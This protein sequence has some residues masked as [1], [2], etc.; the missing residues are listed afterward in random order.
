MSTLGCV[1]QYD[2]IITDRRGEVPVGQL[3]DV[4]GIT[5]ARELNVTSQANVTTPG[6][7]C[8]GL[9]DDGV[10]GVWGRH[11]Q[12]VRDGV[13]VWGPGPI[14]SINYTTGEIVARDISE[15][16]QSR[17]IHSTM[18]FDPA[19]GGVATDA[20]AIAQA[21]VNDAL[22]GDDPN[23][24]PLVTVIPGAPATLRS[25]LPNDSYSL[26]AIQ[27]L[28]Q[29]AL[30]HFTVLGR[31]LIIG[32][33]GTP[34]G[35]LPTFSDDAFTDFNDVVE[36][37]SAL[38]T[39]AVVQGDTVSGSAGGTDPFY[40]L[41]EFLSAKDSSIISAAAATAA[42]AA[43]VAASNPAPTYLQVPDGSIL[44]PDAP[45]DINELVPGVNIPLSITESCRRLF[46]TLPLRR[47]QVTYSA[48]NGEQVRITTA[49]DGVDI[50]TDL[51]GFLRDLVARV[52]RLEHHG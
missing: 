37:G 10:L 45:A 32:P 34:F 26:D 16:I 42:A 2:V 25:Y 14:R 33:Q 1:E 43:I 35:T 29:A 30:I 15:V 7:Q 18:C 50:T 9:L 11:L 19:C 21:I 5:W 6:V 8:C 31:R 4:T 28:T 23:I 49:P 38:I 44:S 40:G 17:V 39:R 51:E 13:T 22:A 3:E 52:R 20:T 47:L 48:A 24:L 41:V 46:A 12:I 27:S 36:D